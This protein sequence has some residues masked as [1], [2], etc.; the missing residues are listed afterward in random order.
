MKATITVHD[1][2]REGGLSPKPCAYFHVLSD[3]RECIFTD[4]VFA[5]AILQQ[6]GAPVIHGAD[7]TPPPD[8]PYLGVHSFTD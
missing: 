5:L 3:S 7:W 8:I 1:Y 6:P 4:A 2:T